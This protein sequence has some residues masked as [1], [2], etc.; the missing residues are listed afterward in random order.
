MADL[1][2]IELVEELNG[3]WGVGHV[4]SVEDTEGVAAECSVGLAM[5]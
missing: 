2:G 4:L 5:L 1:L 3:E